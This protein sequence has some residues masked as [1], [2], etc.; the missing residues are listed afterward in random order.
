MFDRQGRVTGTASR[1]LACD[2]PRSGHVEQDPE[3]LWASTR[4]SAA[5]VLRE[6]GVTL[7][8]V[9]AVGVTN[10]RQTTIAWRRST[11]ETLCPAIVWSSRA[12]RP[13][14]DRLRDRGLA[15]RVRKITGLPIDPTFTATKILL[16]LDE[17]PG[18][19]GGGGESAT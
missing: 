16:L 4:E 10:Q 14:C 2:H 5:E 6:N 18:G 3:Q 12:S 7:A 17:R 15:D 1:P 19:G 8:D 13:V 11:G 9:A